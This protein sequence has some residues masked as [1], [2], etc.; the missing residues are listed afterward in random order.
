[1]VVHR[2]DSWPFDGWSRRELIEGLALR[3][4]ALIRRLAE[5]VLRPAI[6][7]RSVSAGVS[8]NGLSFVGTAAS[9][10]PTATGP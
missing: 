5:P 1:M 4:F 8:A 10:L 3:P 7:C 2:D 6:D 9:I